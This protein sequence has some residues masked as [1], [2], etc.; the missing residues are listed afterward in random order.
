M[1]I[2]SA[3][4]EEPA[5]VMGPPHASD[6]H[7]LA[8][9]VDDAVL[10]ADDNATAGDGG[11]SRDPGTGVEIR[12][13]LAGLEVEDVELAVTRAD[14]DAAGGDDGRRVDA[15]ARRER[16]DRLAGVHVERVHELE[17]RQGDLDVR[18]DRKS[19]RLNS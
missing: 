11:G 1:T 7:L 2:R 18:E 6:Q 15:R 19:T 8:E 17:L 10:R 13:L 3:R 12:Q 5:A 9:R 14:V 4:A 16:P